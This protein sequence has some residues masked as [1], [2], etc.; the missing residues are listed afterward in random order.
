METHTH[1]CSQCF[2]LLDCRR[3]INIR[4]DHQH[5]FLFAFSK[6]FSQ[7][8]HTGGFTGTLQTCHQ[9]NSRRLGRKVQ[10]FIGLPHD[11]LKFRLH[12]FYED[13]TGLQGFGHFCAYSTGLDLGDKFFDY[14]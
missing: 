1:I 14:R 3:T 8:T 4:T 9:D 13:L 10:L 2:Q 12:Y 7:F 11:R 5:F 6:I